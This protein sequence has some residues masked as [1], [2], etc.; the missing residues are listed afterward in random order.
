METGRAGAVPGNTTLFPLP[1][2]GAVQP[3]PYAAARAAAFPNRAAH[4]RLK[5]RLN[6]T[7]PK[8]DPK[9]AVH[10]PDPAAALR[11]G[12]AE[13][14]ARAAAIH[15]RPVQAVAAVATAVLRATVAAADAEQRN[16]LIRILE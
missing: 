3:K 11:A 10:P 9:A 1:K 6:H 8:G 14:A 2:N 13:A 4:S 15:R 16:Q 5:R 12:T 7:L